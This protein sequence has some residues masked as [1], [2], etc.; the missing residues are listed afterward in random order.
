MRRSILVAAAAVSLSAGPALAQFDTLL[1]KH[2]AFFLTASQQ[3]TEFTVTRLDRHHL[4]YGRAVDHGRIGLG[5]GRIFSPQQI[6]YAPRLMVM[7]DGRHGHPLLEIGVTRQW[8][9]YTPQ[10]AN[11]SRYLPTLFEIDV[12]MRLQSGHPLAV[13]TQGRIIGFDSRRPARSIGYVGMAESRDS[14][15]HWIQSAVAGH[16]VGPTVLQL[17]LGL[18]NRRQLYWQVTSTIHRWSW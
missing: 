16:E 12:D 1:F 9:M 8:A 18:T 4:W 15:I 10:F 5:Y 13:R 11:E 14:R 3:S 2:Q 17:G 6:V 7:T